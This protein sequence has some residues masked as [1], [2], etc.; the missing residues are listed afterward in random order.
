MNLNTWRDSMD[1]VKRIAEQDECTLTSLGDALSQLA[2]DLDADRYSALAFI[3]ET[4][5]G[6]CVANPVNPESARFAVVDLCQRLLASLTTSQPFSFANADETLMTLLF[7]DEQPAQ[8]LDAPTADTELNTDPGQEATAVEV[9][10]CTDE[11][12]VTEFLNEAV[13]HLQSS[14]LLML[15]LE[16][17]PLDQDSL[18]ELFRAVHS[19]KGAAGVLELQS[20]GAISHLAEGVLVR[21][22]DGKLVLRESTF[23]VILCAID[24]LRAQL[25]SLAACFSAK[26]SLEYPVPP[27]N[28]IQCLK[29]L[30]ADGQ[31]Q[32][33][34]L[35]QLRLHNLC[36]AQKSSGSR[37]RGVSQSNTLRVDG[38]RLER[39]IDLIGELVI[40]DSMVQRELRG[41]ESATAASVS[42]RLRK[43]VREVQQL[44]LTLKMVPVGNVLQRMHRLVRDLATKLDK[45]VDIQ[46]VGAD[47]EVD[48]TLLECISDPLVHLV[49]NSIDHGI[50][51]T[52]EERVAAGKPPVATIR[53]TAEHRA[54]CIHLQITDDGR[55]LN[56]Q[57][58]FETAV[59][60]GLIAA[61]AHLTDSEIDQLIFIPGFSTATEVTEISGRGVGMDVVR[62][63]IEAMRG[64]ITLTSEPGVG[65]EI[66]LELPLTLSIIDGTVV[67]I[68]DRNFIIPTLSVIEQVQ[69]SSLEFSGNGDCNMVRFRS[70]YLPVQRLGDVLGTPHATFLKHGQVVMI[71]ESSGVQHALIVDEVVGQQP[72]VIKPLGS[73]LAGVTYFAGGALLSDGQIG[74]VLDLNSTCSLAS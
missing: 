36:G 30:I 8:T 13:E 58:I 60:R 59:E 1:H 67:R 12:L 35:H 24:T 29:Q 27:N 51:P 40:T 71:V 73:M 25:K 49:R 5:A 33:E 6:S 21:V 46:I 56:R 31:C 63:N 47:T 68:G 54:G 28:L 42:S 39:L 41:R 62:K 64:S 26:R 10:T 14:E 37:K 15:T 11:Q 66:N 65:T 4:A 17:N 16:S 2:V 69:Y 70:R 50:E 23:E 34:D 20:L 48:K 55:G 44:S 3:A 53:F 61:N 74:F 57:K 43:V 7:P 45:Q 72:V 19:I 52:T 32:E 18:N 38:K 9:C 22:R